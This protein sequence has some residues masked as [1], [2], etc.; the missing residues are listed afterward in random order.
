[1]LIAED[2]NL[3]IAK[4]AYQQQEAEHSNEHNQTNLLIA[5]PAMSRFGIW[6]LTNKTC[7]LHISLPETCS[8]QGYP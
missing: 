7:S 4:T 2:T 6:S 3:L 8:L 1:M 5:L